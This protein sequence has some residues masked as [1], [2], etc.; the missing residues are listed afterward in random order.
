MW[1]LI[2]L[3]KEY[4]SVITYNV[5]YES[6]AQNKILQEAPL[7]ELDLQ[8]KGSGFELLSE[9]FSKRNIEL[10]A[11]NLKSKSK[12]D[13]YFLPA[14]QTGVIQ[15]QL[16]SGLVLEEVLKDTIFLKL[17][18]LSTKK[19]P[20]VPNVAIQYQLGYDIAKSMEVLP[21]EVSISGPELQLE[22]ITSISTNLFEAENVSENI[23]KKLTLVLPKSSEK[24]KINTNEV[25]VKISVDKFTEGEVEVPVEIVNK[26]VG[27]TINMFPKK[28][29]VIFKVGLK[30]F[31]KVTENSFKVVCDYSIAKANDLNYM[32]PRLMTRPD[33]ISNI[34][35]VPSKIDFLI[36]K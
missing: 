24:I 9:N 5:S 15:K 31:N 16:R 36:Y 18:S 11:N 27:M 28:V 21:S 34:R 2:N 1:L 3:S 8:V 33:I 13:Y 20:V 12:S 14:Q 19:V 7:K 22:E 26:P 23:E 25:T 32:E 6:L 4:S 29:K 30:D 35:I 10:F 17:G